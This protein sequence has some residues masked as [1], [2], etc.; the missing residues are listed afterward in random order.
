MYKI[1]SSILII[2]SI[3]FQACNP[4][5]SRK[6]DLGIDFVNTNIN[7]NLRGLSVVDESV[8]W[9]S[10]TNGVVLN[11]KD[12][13]INWQIHNIPGADSLDFRSI[14]AFNKNKAIVVSAGCPASIYLTL[15]GGKTW[16]LK[17]KDDNPAVFLDAI[18][19]WNQSDGLVMGDPVDSALFIL[20]TIDGG[21]NWQRI[22]SENIPQSLSVEGGFAASGSCLALADNDHAWIGTGGDS[23]KVYLSKNAGRSWRVVNTSILSGSPMKGIYSLSFKNNKEGIAVGGEWNVEKPIRSRAFTQDGG[24]TWKLGRGSDTFCS[25]SCYVK[26]DVYLA[27]GQTGIDLSHDGGETW[28][29]VSDL[30]LYGI[31]FSKAGNAGFGTGPSG[32]LVKISLLEL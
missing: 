29:H 3:V 12:G 14:E 5:K 28:D 22:P 8:V 25:G 1:V 31:E 16:D 15:N 10:G 17:W 20:K 7:N 2:L 4:S 11:T 24:I 26:G 13:G 30:H 19:F 21:N 18:S 9:A 32:R 23:A 27:C 6:I